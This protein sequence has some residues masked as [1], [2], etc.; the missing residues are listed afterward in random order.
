MAEYESTEVME[1]PEG[2][3]VAE[4]KDSTMLTG[5]ERVNAAAPGHPFPSVTVSP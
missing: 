3:A 5:S 2:V 1:V 4:V